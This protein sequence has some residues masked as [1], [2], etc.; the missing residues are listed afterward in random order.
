MTLA[1]RMDPPS[2]APRRPARRR[3]AIAALLA[4]VVAAGVGSRTIT[5]GVPWVGKEFGG[6]LWA[7]MFYLGLLLMFPRLRPAATAAAAL[8]LSAGTEFLQLYRAPWI[9]A[10]RATRV[11]GFVLG[12]V[13]GWHDVACYVVGSILAFAADVGIARRAAAGPLPPKVSGGGSRRP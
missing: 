4:I 13:F 2:L 5:G 6:V 11:G 1:A 12:S 10:L 3:W 8:L 7:M 9:D